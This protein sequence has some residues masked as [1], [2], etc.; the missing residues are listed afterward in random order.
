LFDSAIVQYHAFFQKL[1]TLIILEFYAELRAWIMKYCLVWHIEW[2]GYIHSFQ[3]RFSPRPGF[4]VLTGSLRSILFFL[5]YN[6]VVLVKTKNISQRVATEF[7]TGSHRVFPSSIF[8]SIRSGSNPK[9][10]VDLSGR[11][12]FQNYGQTQ[13]KSKYKIILVLGRLIEVFI[14]I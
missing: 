12:G 6:N 8:S 4:R 11:V 10:R 7:L 1:E 9:S 3:T 2:K 5:N 14:Y 13:I